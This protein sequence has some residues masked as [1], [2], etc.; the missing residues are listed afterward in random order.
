M[1]HQCIRCGKLYPSGARQLLEGCDECGGKFFFFI[2]DKK[3]IE[4][5]EEVIKNLSE[6]DKKDMEKDV[7]DIFGDVF[8]PEKPVILDLETIRVVG[9]GKFEIDVCGLMR[10]KPLVINVSDGK[11]FID[12]KSVFERKRKFLKK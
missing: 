5:S 8:S 2:R 3:M 11:Y 9:P 1:P 4:K 12:I 10:G 6:K 7:R